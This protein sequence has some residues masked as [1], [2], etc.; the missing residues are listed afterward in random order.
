[1]ERKKYYLTDVMSIIALCI[2]YIIVAI[3]L[4]EGIGVIT[5]TVI[6]VIV[7]IC[8]VS[9]KEERKRWKYGV[10]WTRLSGLVCLPLFALS[11]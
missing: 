2:G 10:S 3:D 9:A 7:D 1:V 8:I 5:Y 4:M 6:W 11:L